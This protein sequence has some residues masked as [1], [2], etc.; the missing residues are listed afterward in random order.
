MKY[1][2]LEGKAWNFS[3]FQKESGGAETRR[4]EGVKEGN[5]R[6]MTVGVGSWKK[7]L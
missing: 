1:L 3:L 7:G 2:G 5:G 6:F 4:L